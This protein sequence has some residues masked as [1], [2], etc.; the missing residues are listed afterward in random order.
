VI[1]A[2]DD[3]ADAQREVVQAAL[4]TPLS[5]S[6]RS[7]TGGGRGLDAVTPQPPEM[8]PSPDFPPSAVDDGKWLPTQPLDLQ[9]DPSSFDS[10]R[11]Q[12]S[13][14]SANE[15]ANAGLQDRLDEIRQRLEDLGA[16][17]IRVETLPGD[18]KYHCECRMLV[19]PGSAVTETF[20]A[21][22]K[23]A[24]AVAE[25]VLEAIEAWRSSRASQSP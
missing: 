1:H 15:S 22:G 7:Q 10:P 20:E 18:G 6:A 19:T 2:D 5:D 9:F 11:P 8:P 12:G 17:Y 23:D 16:E 21:S 25:Q 24:T 4:E 3:S 13:G 14:L